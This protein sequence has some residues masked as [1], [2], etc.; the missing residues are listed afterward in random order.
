MNTIEMRKSGGAVL[1]TLFGLALCATACQDEER[2]APTADRAGITS[3]TAYFNT[4]ENKGRELFTWSIA[5]SRD[6]TEY[7]IPI[8]YYFP[9]ESDSTTLEAMRSVK[10]VAALE[11]NCVIDPPLGVVDLTR[12][13]SFTYTDP[14]GARRAITIRGEAT[15]SAKCALQSISI[16]DY[17]CV[18]DQAAKTVSIATADDLTGLVAEVV[19][20]PHATISPDPAVPHDFNEP[21]EFTVTADNGTDRAVYTVRKQV[22]PKIANGYAAGSET[23]LFTPLDMT[24]MGKTADQLYATHPTLAATGRYV[25]LCWGTGETPVYFLKATGAQVGEMNIGSATP[26]GAVASDKAGNILISSY[27]E[28]GQEMTIWRTSGVTD[29][30]T[31]LLRYPN[32]LG[33]PVG[34]RLHVNGDIDGDA[35]ITATPYSCN[36]AIRWTVRGGVVGEPE[37]LSLASLAFWGG[38]GSSAKVVAVDPLGSLGAFVDY[39]QGGQCQMYYSPDWQSTQAAVSDGS[40]NAWGLNP[41]ALDIAD[42]N[43]ARYLALFNIGFWPTWVPNSTLYIF[44]A[45]NPA[46]V[47]GAAASSPALKYSAESPNYCTGNHANPSDIAFGD[48]LVTPS[49]DGYFLYV[50]WVSNTHMAL[51]GIQLDC[52]QR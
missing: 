19:L 51:G 49:D 26:T 13:N 9:E 43:G 11:N 18:I 36:N 38:Q 37:N 34:T 14:Y 7:V 30:P 6:M 48:V 3:L 35:V 15:R 2:V 28:S 23:R 32:S 42:F 21:F 39:Y 33:V 40:G 16:G 20:D 47:T 12:A 24:A 29:E 8:P 22:P 44:D 46:S 41:A 45:S 50:F 17:A 5:D 25:V 1:A 10:L 4:G 52:I 27:A 31:V